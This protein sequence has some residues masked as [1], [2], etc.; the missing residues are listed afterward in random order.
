[1]IGAFVVARAFKAIL[2]NF[3]IKGDFTFRGA[4]L[5]KNTSDLIAVQRQIPTVESL[6][7]LRQWLE[8]NVRPNWNFR[9]WKLIK[10]NL[11]G[12]AS[13]WVSS[14]VNKAEAGFY[15]SFSNFD[16]TPAEVVNE[17]PGNHLKKPDVLAA[18]FQD[19]PVRRRTANREM[20]FACQLK[21]P[22]CFRVVYV[23]PGAIFLLAAWERA[24][25][26]INQTR[27]RF[28]SP[29]KSP[30]CGWQ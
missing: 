18:S 2:N 10:N 13:D 16:S 14:H 29:M 30:R 26:Y 12:F 17:C 19:N 22:S 21:S 23:H 7:Q 25:K 24:F 20:D 6:P 9:C 5:V 27:T 28:S 8:N 15:R 4:P 3:R 11:Q 1:M